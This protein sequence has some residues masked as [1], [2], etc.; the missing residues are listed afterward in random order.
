[1][2]RLLTK[3]RSIVYDLFEWPYLSSN[4]L[5]IIGIANSIDL[6]ERSLPLLKIRSSKPCTLV[7]PTYSEAD[8]TLIIRQR[9][10]LCNESLGTEFPLFQEPA[11]RLCVKKVAEM[12]DARRLLDVCK[13][14][15]QLTAP[16]GFSRENA[17][18]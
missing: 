13:N 14:A 8:L 12:G 17:V 2:D 9:V 7:F 11:I 4:V 16:D 10:Q 3:E 1:M 15:L 6:I 5:I 18:K